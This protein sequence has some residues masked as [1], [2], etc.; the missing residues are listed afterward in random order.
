MAFNELRWSVSTYARYLES[1]SG[2]ADELALAAGELE[3]CIFS[4]QARGLG[5]SQWARNFAALGLKPSLTWITVPSMSVLNAARP[6]AGPPLALILRASR[7][8]DKM[9]M[10]RG[11]HQF[12]LDGPRLPPTDLL[13]ELASASSVILWVSVTNER[14]VHK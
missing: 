8:G 6:E 1:M 13:V 11:L 10:A 5:A 4:K 14:T 12:G 2:W 7:E 9:H 3:A